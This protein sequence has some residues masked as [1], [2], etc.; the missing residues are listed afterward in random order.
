[1]FKPARHAR[2]PLKSA[3]TWPHDIRQTT[4]VTPTSICIGPAWP[5]MANKNDWQKRGLGAG[6]WAVFGLRAN[7]THSAPRCLHK[8]DY[9][10]GPIMKKL[11]ILGIIG[12][13]A[14]LTAAPLSPQWSQR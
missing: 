14:I 13:A 6:V 1:M 4:G 7:A 5:D 9:Q 11:A 2:R 10:G 3:A 8:G 12:G